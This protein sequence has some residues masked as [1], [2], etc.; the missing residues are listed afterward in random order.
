MSDKFMIF[1]LLNLNK[2]QMARVIKFR[3]KRIDGKGWTYGSYSSYISHKGLEVN[4]ITTWNGINFD[5]H[6]DTLGQLIGF[7]NNSPIYEGDISSFKYLIFYN[8]SKCLFAEHF[9]Q[10]FTGEYALA[11]YPI[12]LDRIEIIGNIHDNPELL[13]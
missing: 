5:I 7:N 2:N 11:T 4:Y 3:A 6:K 9:K 1:A 10:R 8:E 13:A 12:D